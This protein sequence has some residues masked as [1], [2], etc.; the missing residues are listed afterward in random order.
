MAYSRALVELGADGKRNAATNAAVFLVGAVIDVPGVGSVL[1]HGRTSV[2]GCCALDL[3]T[4]LSEYKPQHLA[5]S[6]KNRF[7]NK[8]ATFPY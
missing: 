2:L 7:T 1:A 6:R 4:I 8:Y 3:F 5:C